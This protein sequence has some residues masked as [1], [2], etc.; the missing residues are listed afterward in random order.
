VIRRAALFVPFK[1]PFPLNA[2]S[3]RKQRFEDLVTVPLVS[4]FQ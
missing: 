3:G 4:D 1:I 2:V